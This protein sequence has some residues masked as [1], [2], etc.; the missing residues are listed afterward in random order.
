MSALREARQTRQPLNVRHPLLHQVRM[1]SAN[2][3]L[4]ADFFLCIFHP[5]PTLRLDAAS[6]FHHPYL[7]S[8]VRDLTTCQQ[9]EEAGQSLTDV[10]AAHQHQS[11]LSFFPPISKM[12]QRRRQSSR[13]SS[14]AAAAALAAAASEA[15]AV[16]QD[17]AA[18]QDAGH[19]QAATTAASMDPGHLQQPGTT[20]GDMQQLQ[21]QEG[22]RQQLQQI[23]EEEEE[24][25]EEEVLQQLQQDKE[26]KEGEV[27]LAAAPSGADT[28]EVEVQTLSAVSNR[29]QRLS[30]LRGVF[31]RKKSGEQDD[32]IGATE[33][34][35]EPPSGHLI[36]AVR[37]PSSAA[38]QAETS[39]PLITPGGTG[40]QD[41][42]S[43]AHPNCMHSAMNASCAFMCDVLHFWH[44]C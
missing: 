9:G 3:D 30:G 15:A 8:T 24:E 20:A 11:C 42:V 43:S 40:S 32:C 17:E 33:S 13:C 41:Q 29:K 5:V 23:V 28:A 2:P 25:E 16:S 4:A 35:N 26:E 21:Q 1:H 27:Q 34:H 44:H 38:P 18:S 6:C 36:A 12:L 31:T 7:A 37:A 19:L 39:G 22:V 10:D 14:A